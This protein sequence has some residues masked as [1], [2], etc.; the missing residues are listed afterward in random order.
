VSWT[1]LALLA[2]AV[3]FWGLGAHGLW[4]DE[5]LSLASATGGSL[6]SPIGPG[7]RTFTVEDFWR[8]NSLAGVREAVAH[9]ELGNGVLHVVALHCWIALFGTSDAS[10][11]ALSVLAGVGLVL[12][13]YAL[14]NSLWSEGVAVA[15]AVLLSLHPML[16]RYSREARGYA[17]ATLLALAATCV[18]VRLGQ[19]TAAAP[20][21]RLRAIA[22]G[23]VTGAALLSHYL[24]AALFAGHLAFALLRVRESR[25]WKSLALGWTLAAVMVAAWMA[26]GGADGLRRMTARNEMYRRRVE[27]QTARHERPATIRNLGHD[28]AVIAHHL[29]GNEID[30]DARMSLAETL[31]LLVPCVLVGVALLRQPAAGSAVILL[32]ILATAAP[33]QAVVLALSAGHTIAL[34]PR[35]AL[36]SAPYLLLLMAAGLSTMTSLRGRWRAVPAAAVI[37][38]GALWARSLPRVWSD[39]PRFRPPNAYAERAARLAGV[40]L[41]SDVVVHP[42]WQSAR[43][44]ALYLPRGERFVQKVTPQAAAAPLRVFREGHPV[45]ELDMPR[46]C[47]KSVFGEPLDDRAWTEVKTSR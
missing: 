33:A 30:L 20:R 24:V 38:L 41:P 8:A 13:A 1:A 46:A 18:F 35:Y 28:L 4:C 43:L 26:V 9:Q 21:W 31:L 29:T 14:A 19:G 5:L 7:A 42:H 22:Y 16:V 17:L 2:G 39:A 44:C 11:R 34:I 3:R 32:V 6:V 25:V 27:Q 36:F 23:L 10:V 12:L 45:F 37:V 47:P 40:V 15:A